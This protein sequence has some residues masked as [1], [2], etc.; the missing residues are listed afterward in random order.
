MAT[1][2]SQ[3][4]GNTVAGAERRDAGTGRRDHVMRRPAGVGGRQPRRAAHAWSAR[5]APGI[6]Q[7][8]G[9]RVAAMPDECGRPRRL[10]G[11]FSGGDSKRIDKRKALTGVLAGQG[12]AGGELRRF[13]L[14][15]PAEL[16]KHL[17]SGRTGRP[18]QALR[19]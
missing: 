6:D 10:W 5:T 12:L 2:R 4:K 13:E 19:C 11:R 8:G 16:R 7:G 14:R 3:K 17:R 18:D 9:D 15:T 1:A